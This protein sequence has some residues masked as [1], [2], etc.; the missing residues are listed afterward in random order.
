MSE[1]G[2][3]LLVAGVALAV[4]AT[5]Q[6]TKAWIASAMHLHESIAVFSWFNL[7]YVRNTGAAF[8]MFADQSSAF[9]VPIFAAAA[10]VGGVAIAYFVRQTPATQRSVLIACGLVL[11]G[12]VGNLIDRVA[13]G[14]VIDFADAHWHGMHW[15]A[16]NVADSGISVGVCLLLLRGIFVRDDR[17]R[18]A[19]RPAAA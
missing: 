2:K 17:E 19:Q 18:E 7:T 1:S 10:L 6:F 16:F 8:S 11:G 4:V 3:Y 12:A 5:D 15:P 13:H 9:R 14:E